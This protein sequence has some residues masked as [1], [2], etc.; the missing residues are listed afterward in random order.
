MCSVAVLWT[1]VL[2]I[3][4][5]D[6]VCST[7]QNVSLL[8]ILIKS[9]FSGQCIVFKEKGVIMFRETSE[10]YHEFYHEM[11]N[12]CHDQNSWQSTNYNGITMNQC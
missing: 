4:M 1:V 10:F 5:D 6:L 7:T 8:N 12:K 9:D 11:S 3:Y 2:S